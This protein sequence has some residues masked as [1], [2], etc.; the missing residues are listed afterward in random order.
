MLN[1]DFY[2]PLYTFLYDPASLSPAKRAGR[3]RRP[4][5]ASSPPPAGPWTRSHKAI[6]PKRRDLRRDW[7][8]AEQLFN[9]LAA[10]TLVLNFFLLSSVL[11][12]EYTHTKPPVFKDKSTFS[13]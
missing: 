2:L 7:E 11:F 10:F 12:I 1:E 3:R 4:M 13:L 8:G 9:Q 5:P 6:S